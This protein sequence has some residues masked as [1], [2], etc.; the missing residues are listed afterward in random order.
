MS[1]SLIPK[2]NKGYIYTL[3]S[4]ILLLGIISM[5]VHYA[6]ISSQKARS[7]INRIQTDELSAVVESVKEDFRNTLE[8]SG[9]RATVFLT[10]Y[11]A[12]NFTN[13]TDYELIPC[14]EIG[15]FKYTRTGAPAAI[16]ELMLCGTIEGSGQWSMERMNTHTLVNW[17]D[18][19]NT[20]AKERD[21][22]VT[23]RFDDIL[24]APY[25]VWT[26]AFIGKVSIFGV[27]TL[28]WSRYDVQ[29]V[30]VVSGIEINSVEDPLNIVLTGKPGLGSVFIPCNPGAY[31]IING[32]I[33]DLW[34]DSGCHLEDDKLG[35]SFF[36]RLE[37]RPW[38]TVNYRELREEVREAMGEEF[39]TGPSLNLETVLDLDEWWVQNVSSIPVDVDRSW[40][41][42]EYF[43]SP[44]KSF[45]HPVDSV[46]EDLMIDSRHL[47]LYY[48]SNYYSPKRA[49]DCFITITNETSDYI[50]YPPPTHFDDPKYA[51]NN[52]P[53][54]LGVN[55]TWMNVGNLTCNLTIAEY[56]SGAYVWTV[57]QSL[58]P[59]ENFSYFFNKTYTFHTKPNIFSCYNLSAEA[60]NK[61]NRYGAEICILEPGISEDS[62]DWITYC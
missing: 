34:M 21:V 2:G 23:V 14:P 41:D 53:F 4:V 48:V 17:S 6:Q 55:F 8:I 35:A 27:D 31:S 26:I 58:K 49:V 7:N 18:R 37:G 24:V 45:C 15:D 5:N 32:T 1:G 42:G 20:Y 57:N 62:G 38:T 46:H 10:G 39:V 40:V 12:S 9:G 13:L 51:L 28:G 3:I 47:Y 56:E 60:N 59:W 36:D 19:V 43:F 61:P 29:S 30:P 33:L 50:Y 25:D 11:L 44:Y 16:A 22:N 54:P 52:T